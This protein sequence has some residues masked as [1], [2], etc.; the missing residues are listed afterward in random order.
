MKSNT[1]RY[2]S[3]V[4]RNLENAKRNRA[5]WIKKFEGKPMARKDA[6]RVLGIRKDDDSRDAEVDALLAGKP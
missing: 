1:E 5:K 6:K 2:K 3:A 4:D